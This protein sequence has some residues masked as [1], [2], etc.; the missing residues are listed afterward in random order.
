M[1][2][3]PTDFR[4]I[5]VRVIHN[6]SGMIETFARLRSHDTIDADRKLRELWT[7]TISEAT[8]LRALALV[9]VILT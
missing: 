6:D 8:A 1:H 5:R 4:T 3:Q 2:P 9:R 7:A